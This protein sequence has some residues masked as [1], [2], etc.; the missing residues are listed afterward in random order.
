MRDTHLHTHKHTQR[1][2]WGND[3]H[4]QMI[5]TAER[6]CFPGKRFY[7]YFAMLSMAITY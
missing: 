7:T 4:L 5:E 3:A 6:I 1:A 2:V